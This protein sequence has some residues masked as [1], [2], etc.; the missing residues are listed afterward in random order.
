LFGG[1][2]GQ[3]DYTGRRRRKWR[4]RRHVLALEGPTVLAQSANRS[5]AGA[6]TTLQSADFQRELQ[7]HQPGI[8]S[9]RWMWKVLKAR[10][11][12]IGG[13]FPH[14]VHNLLRRLGN[15]RKPYF[16]AE[17]RDGLRYLGDYRDV[18]SMSYALD[19]M[20][21]AD[22]LHELRS[23]LE[24]RPGAF[25]DVGANLGL[26]SAAMART[27]PERHVYAIEPVPATVRRAAAT[28]A[29]NGLTNVTLVPAAAGDTDGEIVFYDAPGCSEYASAI[30]TEQPINV[31]WK[32][33][34]VP[35]L[36]LDTL[37]ER[38][39]MGEVA[40]LKIDAEGYEPKVI[41]GA[42]A[43][44]RRARPNI[45]YEYNDSVAPAAGWTASD[46]A[47]QILAMGSYS[48][49]QLRENGDR[50]PFAPPDEVRGLL[51][52]FCRSLARD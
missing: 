28:F 3:T 46:V 2:F 32:E 20:E 49:F 42:D 43:L 21:V 26:Y 1:S 4:R 25:V 17:Y 52:I 23:L 8:A 9:Y 48:F 33:M 24:G 30:P 14:K 41:A 39:D 12:A 10:S 35:C 6:V 7:N 22:P 40:L 45:V 31:Q 16:I 19:A 51:N 36:R 34:R 44:I 5:E 27:F 11:R 37:A 18:N 50:L 47:V 13:W 15:P 29:L 38:L